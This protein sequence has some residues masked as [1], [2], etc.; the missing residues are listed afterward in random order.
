M[1]RKQKAIWKLQREK[2]NVIKIR[3]LIRKKGSKIKSSQ[4]KIRIKN[5]LKLI[6]NSLRPQIRFCN[7]TVKIV[8]ELRFRKPNVKQKYGDLLLD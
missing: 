5:C 1:W 7:R 2:Y 8:Y 4:G 6:K 3:I